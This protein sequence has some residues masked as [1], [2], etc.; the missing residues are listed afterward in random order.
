M[1]DITTRLLLNSKKVVDDIKEQLVARKMRQEVL[2]EIEVSPEE[3]KEFYDGIP[4]DS[5]PYFSTQVKVSQ[6]VKSPEVGR[7]KKKKLEMS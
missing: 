2:N 5:L 4:R 1:K 7:D 3:V 6:I